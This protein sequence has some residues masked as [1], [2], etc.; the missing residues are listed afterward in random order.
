M[1]T[2]KIAKSRYFCRIIMQS[3]AK[4]LCYKFE[5]G[6]GAATAATASSVGLDG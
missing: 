5:N 6:L 4:N 1:S 2:A 3:R